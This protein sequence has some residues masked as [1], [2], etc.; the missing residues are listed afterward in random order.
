MRQN[1]FTIDPAIGFVLDKITKIQTR[2]KKEKKGGKNQCNT[3]TLSTVES[4]LKFADQ[5]FLMSEI[6][7]KMLAVG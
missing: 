2:S 1:Y 7:R 5:I 4:L 3:A 6:L